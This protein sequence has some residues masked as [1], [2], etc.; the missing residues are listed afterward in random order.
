MLAVKKGV[1]R[2]VAHKAIKEY[3]L[4]RKNE[5]DFFDLIVEDK[6]LQI[7]RAEIEN[8]RSNP[9][10][11]AGDAASQA[12]LSSKRIKSRLAGKT[13]LTDFS[14]STLR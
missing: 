2:E 4:N 1:G 8:L 7:D 11:L 13:D 12:L 9:S 5:G 3:S 6:T 10:K 14:P